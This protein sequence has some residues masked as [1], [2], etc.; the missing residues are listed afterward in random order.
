MK[1]ILKLFKIYI[2]FIIISVNFDTKCYKKKLKL[3][4]L[5]TIKYYHLIKILLKTKMFFFYVKFEIVYGH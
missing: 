3:F 5:T 1:K 2:F 4:N